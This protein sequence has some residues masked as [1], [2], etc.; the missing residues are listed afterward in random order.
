MEIHRAAKLHQ[1]DIM[2]AQAHH[3]TEDCA[4]VRLLK[5]IRSLHSIHGQWKVKAKRSP[6][7]K[8][9]SKVVR[10]QQ[11]IQPK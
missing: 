7:L 4:A 3:G 8:L 1:R 2:E 10:S 5:M 9:G 11:N 6:L